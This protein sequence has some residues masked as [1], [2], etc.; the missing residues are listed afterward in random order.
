[1]NR[2]STRILVLLALGLFA[3][4]F[5]VERHTTDTDRN[6]EVVNLLFPE[7][8]AAET[9]G[10]DI[11][12]STNPPLK[13]E[14][15][16]GLWRF[17][18]PFS[19]PAQPVGPD[20]L[21]TSLG[22]LRRQTH[23]TAQE[24]LVQ[25][26]G[27]AAFGFTPPSAS[28]VF[29]QGNQALELRLGAR[30]LLGNQVYLQIVGRDGLYAVDAEF[31]KNLPASV[32]AWRDAALLTLSGV[33]F[34]RLEIR[35]GTNGFEVTRNPTNQF[36]QMT[37]P[38]LTRANKAKLDF[39][40][41]DLQLTRVSQFV[42]D[43]PRA[44]LE[45][46]GLQ[47]PERELVFG[48]GTNDLVV[49]QIGRSPTNDPNF[50]FLRRLSNTN[51]VLA[52]RAKIEPWLASFREFCDRRLMV[53]T[54]EAVSRIEAR[55]DEAFALQRGTNG[56]WRIVEPYDA[57]ADPVLAIELLANLAEMEF[58][59]FEREV[60]TDFA[61]YGLMPPRR[62]LILKST[63]ASPAGPPTNIILAQ[64]DLGNP[65]GHKFFA[66]RS[67]ENSVVTALDNGRLPRT[68]AELRNRRIWDVSTNQIASITIRQG[69]QVRKLIRTGP[70][71]W[72]HAPGSEGIINRY[73]IEEAAFRL[74]Q[75]R[76][77]TWVAQGDDQ[78]ARYGIPT[79]DHQITI[80]LLPTETPQALT[81]RF[82]RKAP[83]R[84]TYASVQLAGQPAP[85]IFECPLPIWEFVE[86]NL[87]AL[88]PPTASPTPP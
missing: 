73:A 78:L 43:D 16:N 69:G 28:L 51:V 6:A 49:L 66:R 26:N 74:G 42:T 54:P 24:V 86:G 20:R 34:D 61:P 19:Y 15:T 57:P 37:K 63:L 22:D 14:R 44:D 52:P 7:F 77:E 11:L 12:I 64:L 5:L 3:F 85:V 84:R 70:S 87:T 68:A 58:L 71:Q 23:L 62:Q 67:L 31:L 38:L 53:F 75:L 50:V 47:P 30:T 39:L 81:V 32:N 9:T 33:G 48:Q 45:P 1:M 4:I 29:H 21:L 10:V 88:R 13:L 59:E 83:S 56:V 41:Q 35:P 40:L 2:N 76:A 79:T 72:I 8:I 60:V 17:K 27:L 25:T 18:S 46:Y 55:V 36:W 80:E 82:G 65:S